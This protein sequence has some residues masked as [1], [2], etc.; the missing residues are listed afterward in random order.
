MKDQ[1]DVDL[2]CTELKNLRKSQF[3]NGTLKL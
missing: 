1:E 3:Q 2:G